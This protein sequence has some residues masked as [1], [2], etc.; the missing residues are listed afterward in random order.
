M[1]DKRLVNSLNVAFSVIGSVIGAGFI[2]GREIIKFFM[3]SNVI[4][5]GFSVFFAFFLFL[6]LLM[7]NTSAR[8]NRLINGSNYAICALNLVIIASMLSATDSLFNELFNL[9]SNFFI[10]SLSLL[11]FSTVLCVRGINW[12][13]KFNAVFVPFMLAVLYAVILISPSVE[14]CINR[15]LPSFGNCFGYVAMNCFLAQPL[16]CELKKGKEKFSP[17]LVSI[18]SAFVLAV[19]IVLYLTVLNE[20][21]AICDI[22]VLSLFKN[23]IFVKAIIAFTIFLGIVTTQLSAHYPILKIGFYKKSAFLWVIAVNLVCFLIS[24][25]G[26]YGIVDLLYPIIANLSLI[27]FILL[28]SISLI[29]FRV[30]KRKHTSAKQVC[31]VA[32]CSTLRDRVLKLDRHTR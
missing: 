20:E 29:A 1:K 2:T 30:A 17:F 6:F 19:T 15:P 28:I 21:C 9:K 10:F 24:R 13:K 7:S 26:F 25:I 11:L 18:I 23:L 16:I 14:N 3:N 8:V 5:V 4:V 22:P 27:Y 12:I 32:P 31:K